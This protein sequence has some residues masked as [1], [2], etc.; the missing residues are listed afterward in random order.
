MAKAFM[1][2][3]TLSL[4]VALGILASPNSGDRPGGALC[5]FFLAIPVILC[6][7]W[8]WQGADRRDDERWAAR[9]NRPR[10]DR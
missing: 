10:D 8:I 4:G 1:C 7:L 3:L 2:V 9:Q 6:A 5:G